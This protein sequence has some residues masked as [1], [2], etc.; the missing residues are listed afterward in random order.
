[1]SR[2]RERVERK[3][4]VCRC[5]KTLHSD[6][7]SMLCYAKSSLASNHDVELIQKG[8]DL[9]CSKG[10]RTKEN[11]LSLTQ[12][13]LPR[14]ITIE[15]SCIFQSAPNHVPAAPMPAL[16]WSCLVRGMIL[17]PSLLSWTMHPM[18]YKRK[19]NLIRCNE[20][21]IWSAAPITNETFLW[22]RNEMRWCGVCSVWNAFLVQ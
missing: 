16:S 18:L 13:R 3:L 5:D 8:W 17:C 2:G 12:I 1:M 14:P 19:W 10:F 20:C 11:D 4:Y 22:C 21:G 7:C 9:E 15:L 6:I